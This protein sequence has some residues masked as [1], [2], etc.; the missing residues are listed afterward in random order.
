MPDGRLK[1]FFIERFGLLFGR[2]LVV[3]AQNR[4][5]FQFL[6][7]FVGKIAPFFRK[8]FDWKVVKKRASRKESEKHSKSLIK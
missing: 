7:L 8:M 6:S 1:E 4:E 2:D 5:F 3:T